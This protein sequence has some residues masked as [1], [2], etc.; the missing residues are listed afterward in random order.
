MS[1]VIESGIIGNGDTKY[2][3]TSKSGDYFVVLDSLPGGCTSLEELQSIFDENVGATITGI[4]GE[5]GEKLTASSENLLDQAA[6]G[7]DIK[8]IVDLDFGLPIY[9]SK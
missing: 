9:N 4:V 5:S 7:K 1:K 6:T 3:I 8:L 2:V